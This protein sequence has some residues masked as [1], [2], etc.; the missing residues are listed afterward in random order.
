M[1]LRKFNYFKKRLVWVFSI[2][3]SA[4][5]ITFETSLIFPKY[6]EFIALICR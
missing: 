5:D 4:N 1:S 6:D 2:T 3:L